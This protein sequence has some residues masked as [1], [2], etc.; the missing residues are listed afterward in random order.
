VLLPLQS[1]VLLLPPLQSLLLPLRSLLL[2]LPLWCR[3]GVVVAI[4]S[5]CR[6]RCDAKLVLLPLWCEA[7]AV[8]T[9]SCKAGGAAAISTVAIG[10]DRIAGIPAPSRVA[11]YKGDPWRSRILSGAE[12]KRMQKIIN[13]YYLTFWVVILTT[14]LAWTT[15]ALA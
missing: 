13:S 10:R 9:T 1:L 15:G 2:L 8:A 7:R 11:I 12:S 5:S 3:V 14:M 6:C 4:R